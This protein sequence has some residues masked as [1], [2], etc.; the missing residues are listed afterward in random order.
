MTNAMCFEAS[1]AAIACR[2]G[3]VCGCVFGCVGNETQT[4][5]PV[6]RHPRRTAPPMHFGTMHHS[7]VALP[8]LS[9]NLAVEKRDRRRFRTS[10]DAPVPPAPKPTRATATSTDPTDTTRLPE[11]KPSAALPKASLA[12]LTVN[13]VPG[14]SSGKSAA[15]HAQKK[16]LL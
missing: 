14:P 16:Y 1:G 2:G 10:H 15:R 13:S 7:L 12:S 3:R 9:R 11:A 6:Q 8:F 4:G 5:P